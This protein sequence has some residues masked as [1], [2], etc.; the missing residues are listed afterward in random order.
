MISGK[1]NV[2][3]VGQCHLTDWRIS[4]NIQTATCMPC[5]G[6]Y[7]SVNDKMT[8]FYGTATLCEVKYNSVNDECHTPYRISCWSAGARDNVLTPDIP[9]FNLPSSCSVSYYEYL[10]SLYE[11]KAP[12]S[13]RLPVSMAWY[14]V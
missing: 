14:T 2:V 5:G 3:T 4:E 1:R 9:V 10:R 12:A 13:S 7:Y 6:Y 8:S 11:G